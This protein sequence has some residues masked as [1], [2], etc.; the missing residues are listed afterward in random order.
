MKPLVQAR[1]QEV[2]IEFLNKKY[3]KLKVAT[4]FQFK[5]IKH[6]QNFEIE[7]E[8]DSNRDLHAVHASIALNRTYF[9]FIMSFSGLKIHH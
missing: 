1:V 3:Q 4:N 8:H 2:Q 9:P 7:Y 6:F 5:K